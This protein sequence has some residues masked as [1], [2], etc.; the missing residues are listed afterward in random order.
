MNRQKLPVVLFMTCFCLLLSEA[1]NARVSSITGS[2]SIREGYDS[3]IDRTENNEVSGWTTT[4]SPALQ[5]NSQGEFGTVSI[6]Y[7][8]G[9]SYD[10]KLKEN[11]IDH[12]F[13]LNGVRDLSKK[14]RAS[15]RETYI[16]SSNTFIESETLNIDGERLIREYNRTDRLETNTVSVQ[17][18]YEYALESLFTLSYANH[19]LNHLTDTTLNRDDYM[20]HNPAATLSHRINHKWSIEAF[21]SYIKGNFDV[22]ED[23]TSHNP[24]LRIN[25]LRTPL[26]TL[27][28]SYTLRDTSYE[29]TQREDYRI[30]DIALGVDHE[31]NSE[32]SFTLSL[33]YSRVDRSVSQDEEDFNGSFSLTK[34][35]KRGSLRL[36]ARGGFDES[37][38]SGDKQGLS[39]Y[40]TARGSFDYQLTEKSKVD[41]FAGI[42]IDDYSESAIDN[43]EKAFFGGGGLSVA[44]ARWFTISFRYNYL[45]LEA[46]DPAR[47]D[48]VDHR[49]YVSLAAAKELW[50]W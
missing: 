47:D 38:F 50:R 8:P 45:Q 23:I 7:S 41:V 21:Y 35:T 48:Y 27:F 42:R 13:Y 26:S 9:F 32:S 24:G 18:D 37:Q 29:G 49:V 11:E 44:F 19:I 3:N 14:S 34:E 25:Y 6:G 36:L 40:S 22:S 1:A 10:H 17:T 4:I 39:L 30:H 15:L 33:G 43:D 12:R 46:D 20:R 31:I 2:I 5:L 16:R 28:G